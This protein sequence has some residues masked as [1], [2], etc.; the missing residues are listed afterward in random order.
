MEMP[1]QASSGHD[2]IA[3]EMS[4]ASAS[5]VLGQGTISL[6][7]GRNLE[8]GLLTRIFNIISRADS[9]AEHERE[10]MCT[11]EEIS[12]LESCGY[13]LTSY[14]RKGGLYRTVFVV[15]FSQVQALDRLVQSI[16]EELKRGDVKL[17]L[18]WRGGNARIK[19]VQADLERLNYFS[20]TIPTYRQE[21][22]SELRRNQT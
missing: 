22:G 2:L 7:L 5:I 12:R 8:H 14:A 20:R 6:W 19:M 18:R 9:S 15:P 21:Q 1:A 17:T 13:I 4:G 16:I 3:V 11:F 10:V